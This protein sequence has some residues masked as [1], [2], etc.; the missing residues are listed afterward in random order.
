MPVMQR[1]RTTRRSLLSWWKGSNVRRKS[2]LVNRIH[3]G[4][5]V[6]HELFILT[7]AA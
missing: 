2:R 7:V 3:R 4:V 5:G 6:R 1:R